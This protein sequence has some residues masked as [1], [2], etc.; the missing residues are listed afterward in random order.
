MSSEVFWDAITKVGLEGKSFI[1]GL[2][3]G[4]AKVS[5]LGLDRERLQSAM[6]NGKTGSSKKG[7]EG[8]LSAMQV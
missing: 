7:A 4:K 2:H 1:E 6:Q 8:P 5:E 3:L